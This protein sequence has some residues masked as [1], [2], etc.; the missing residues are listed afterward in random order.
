M[1]C[2]KCGTPNVLGERF[3]KN[4][5]CILEN[6]NQQP[7]SSQPQQFVSQQSQE[8]PYVQTNMNANINQQS[9]NT[10][11]NYQQPMY[12]NSMNTTNSQNMNGNLNSNYVQ[13]AVNP[14]MKKWAILSIVVPVAGMIWYWFIGLSFY[15]AILI[16]TAGFSFAQKGEMANKKMAIVGKVLNG[17]LC[18]MAI[19]MLILQLI[20][21]FSQ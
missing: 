7:V 19:I 6:V 1:N 3:C 10:N 21:A 14:N 12:N 13:Q 11:A 2:Q 4:C 15:L 17:M 9:M 18:A 8:Q 20:E 5:G 16:A